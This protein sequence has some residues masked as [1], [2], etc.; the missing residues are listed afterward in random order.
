MVFVARLAL[1]LVLCDAVEHLTGS[2][3]TGGLAVAAY[4]V[5]SQF[6]F[7]NS[8]F[9]YQT[10]ALPLAL[11]AVAFIARARGPVIPVRY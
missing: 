9:S 5:S 2:S 6:V 7:F 1:V 11:A 3:R 10:L 4:A 8:M